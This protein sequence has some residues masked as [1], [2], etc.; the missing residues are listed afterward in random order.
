M[1]VALFSKILIPHE[2]INVIRKT[3]LT[4]AVLSN[5]LSFYQNIVFARQDF[6]LPH[7]MSRMSQIGVTNFSSKDAEAPVCS[8]NAIDFKTSEYSELK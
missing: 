5:T 7:A 2:D 6:A 4:S 3:V 1:T 8:S